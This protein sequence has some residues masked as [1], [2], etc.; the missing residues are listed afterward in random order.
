MDYILLVKAERLRFTA[1]RSRGPAGHAPQT[2]GQDR[3]M[4]LGEATRIPYGSPCRLV[5]DMSEGRRARRCAEAPENA[6]PG[7]DDPLAASGPRRW[8]GIDGGNARLQP[9]GA[10]GGGQ[11]DLGACPDPGGPQVAGGYPGGSSDEFEVQGSIIRKARHGVRGELPCPREL[12]RKQQS[13]PPAETLAGLV[14]AQ[15]AHAVRRV[16]VPD[17]RH[18][19][20]RGARLHDGMCLAHL[21]GCK[22]S[23]GDEE[24][25][26]CHEHRSFGEP[27]ASPSGWSP[28][29]PA[30]DTG[31]RRYLTAWRRERPAIA[32]FGGD[33]S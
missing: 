26:Q 8:R 20:L 9:E 21:A 12:W 17:A 29:G 13:H 14:Q 11:P 23:G 15:H 19:A 22:G 6:H 30:A 10:T 31:P 33:R 3:A 27:H 2:A 1:R 5:L 16:E 25:R 28:L 18:R 24:S 4:R 7:G 32:A